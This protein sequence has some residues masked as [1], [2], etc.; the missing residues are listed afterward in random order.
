MVLPNYAFDLVNKRDSCDV[1]FDNYQ[2]K[3]RFYDE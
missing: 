3:T 2:Q 1:A